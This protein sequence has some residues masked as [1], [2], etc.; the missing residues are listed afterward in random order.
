MYVQ[1]TNMQVKNS[2]LLYSTLSVGIFNVV[3]VGTVL[4]TATV[5]TFSYFLLQLLS[6]PTLK[7]L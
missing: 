5:P 7:L 3:V 1:C 4:L 2:A 6:L